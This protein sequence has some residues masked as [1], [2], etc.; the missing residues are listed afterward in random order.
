MSTNTDPS[1]NTLICQWTKCFDQKTQSDRLNN[2][3]RTYNCC[4]QEAHFRTKDTQI[5]SEGVVF[6]EMPI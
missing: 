2:E 4:L 1:I 6:G 3:T 5:K